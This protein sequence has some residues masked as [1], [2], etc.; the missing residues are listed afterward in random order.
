MLHKTSGIDCSDNVKGFASYLSGRRQ[1]VVLNGQA[2]DWILGVLQ[3]S[4]LGPLFLLLYIN[5]KVKH[6]GCSV[7]GFLG[8]DDISIYII[9]DCPNASAWCFN[10]NLQT[11]SQWA[12]DWLINFN[13]NLTFSMTI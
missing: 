13:A 3:G 12:E 5:D 10:A 7:R 9:V 4:I 8:A 1:R 2:S 11:V 6:I